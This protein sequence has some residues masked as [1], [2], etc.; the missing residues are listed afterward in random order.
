MSR[1]IL[2]RVQELDWNS[3][4]RELDDRGSA[5]TSSLLSADECAELI[6]LYDQEV[7]RKRVD[8]G[9]HNYGEG[10]YKYFDN[11]LPSLVSQLRTELYPP[12][13]QVANRW[14]ERLGEETTYPAEHAEL[15]ARCHEQEQGKPTPL[16]LRYEAEG[17]NCLHQ[18]LYGAVAFPLQVVF[19]LSRPGSDFTG[20]EFLLVEQRPRAQSRGEAIE[21]GQGEA[22]IFATHHRPVFKTR[23]WS[24]INVRHGVSRIRSGRRFTLGIIFHDAA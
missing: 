20:G 23:G 16:L 12:L 9:R 11:P 17:F 22:I 3:L 8:M 14:A 7:F 18:D 21:L 19:L 15:L 13:A 5:Q 4:G 2:Q 6:A 10:E 1:S 24:R